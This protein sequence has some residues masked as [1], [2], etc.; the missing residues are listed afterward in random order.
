ME[1]VSPGFNELTRELMHAMG[2][3]NRRLTPMMRNATRGEMAVGFALHSA[4]ANLTPGEIAEKARLSTART[5]NVLAAL[6]K[7]GWVVREHSTS[8]RRMVEVTMTDAGRVE[9]ERRHQE[10]MRVIAAFLAKLGEEDARELLRIA[11]RM[12]TVIDE[13]QND[14]NPHQKGGACCHEDPQAV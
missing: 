3:V 7:K 13:L 10:G 5:A 9:F 1:D 2:Q 12:V 4:N 6:E 14:P 8:D 11:Q